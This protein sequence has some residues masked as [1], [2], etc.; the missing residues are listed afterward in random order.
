MDF[1]TTLKIASFISTVLFAALGFYTNQQSKKLKR[2]EESIAKL[3]K[4][5]K[6]RIDYEEEI[7]DYLTANSIEVQK[8]A[9]AAKRFMREIYRRS[10]NEELVYTLRDLDRF[11]R[12]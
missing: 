9:L 8:S 6:A 12:R 4:E 2:K 3:L 5:L 1:D 7:C 10:S 11:Y